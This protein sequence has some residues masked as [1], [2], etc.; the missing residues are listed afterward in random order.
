MRA[1]DFTNDPFGNPAPLIVNPNMV[2]ADTNPLVFPNVYFHCDGAGN[3]LPANPDG[4]QAPGTAC[5]K[6][7]GTLI[8]PIGQAMINLYPNPNA[9]NASAGINYTSQ[10][11]RE[12]DDTRFDIRL[13]HTLSANG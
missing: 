6:L 7:P 3:A 4:S 2:G 13:D 5:N 8:N 11:V 12:L 10:P 9:N 1:G